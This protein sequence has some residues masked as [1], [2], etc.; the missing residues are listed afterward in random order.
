MM[1]RVKLEVGLVPQER[2]GDYDWFSA[3]ETWLA[4]RKLERTGDCLERTR[5]KSGNPVQ[6]S[7]AGKDRTF[8]RRLPLAIVHDALG[9]GGAN[10]G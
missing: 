9:Q 6:I 8:P 4:L 2:F 5:A 7:K 3:A 1:R 10:F